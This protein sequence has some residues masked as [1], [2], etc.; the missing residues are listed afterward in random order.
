[1]AMEREAPPDPGV[2]P[3]PRSRYRS[4]PEITAAR[5]GGDL[6][7]LI[8]LE[9]VVTLCGWLSCGLPPP[10]AIARAAVTDAGQPTGVLEAT[11]PMPGELAADLARVETYLGQVRAALAAL[12]HHESRSRSSG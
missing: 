4:A 9:E 8:V 6:D 5:P 3:D 7:V 11:L 2:V 12:A 10:E 1:M